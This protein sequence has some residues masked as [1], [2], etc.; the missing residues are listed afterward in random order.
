MRGVLILGG[1]GEARELAEA[2]HRNGVPVTSSLAGRVAEPALPP[3]EVRIGGF[4]GSEGLARWLSDH[5]I[6]AVVDASHPF[7]VRISTSAATACR[8][9]GVALTRLERPAW[10]EQPADR[11]HQV[12]DLAGAAEEVGRRG[13]RVLLTTGRLEAAAF[14]GIEGAW[15]LV[16]CI[17]APEPPLPPRRELLLARG[18]YTV[19]GEM[20][21]LERHRIDLVVTKNSGGR[22]TA[23][24]V[25][26]ARRCQLPVVMVRRPQPPEVLTVRS[27]AGALRRLERIA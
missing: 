21:L 18:P 16:R 5:R 1:T 6:A 23:A 13:G 2:L 7:A 10:T 14:A 19:E 22:H 17:T 26:A 11:W 24:K 12:D 3:G 27:V 25:E 20:A 9:A 15:F 8:D 4:G